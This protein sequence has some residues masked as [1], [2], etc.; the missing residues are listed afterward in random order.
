MKRPG[1]RRLHLSSGDWTG[2][3][4]GL[5]RRAISLADELTYLHLSTTFNDG[6][7]SSMRD[8]PLPLKEVLSIKEWPQLSHLALSRFS[9]DTSELMDILKLAPSSLRSLDLEF[10]E[11]P[12]DELG[13]TG[14]LE[15]M[16]E[17]VDW[18]KRDLKPTVTIGMEGHR[19]WSGRFRRGSK[20]SLWVWR[21]SPGWNRY[22]QPQR[23]VRDES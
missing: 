2:F 9:V 16:P 14:L 7:H 19:V 18:S 20:L 3:Q 11:F 21:K 5:F 13:L 10:I 15:R 1:F 4:S 8:P 6:S 17:E 12:F 23:R 22:T